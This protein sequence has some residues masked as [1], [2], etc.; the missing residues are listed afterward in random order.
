MPDVKNAREVPAVEPVWDQ[1]RA[2][3][4]ETTPSG[5]I[6]WLR[7]IA[8][9]DRR[10]YLA[11]VAISLATGIV[12]ALSAAQDAAWRGGAYDLRTPLLW[13]TSSV[14]MI[15]LLAPILF[16]AVWR[17]RRLSSWPLRIGLAVAAI[18]VFSTLHIAGM[19]GIRKL[20][21]LLARGSYDFHLSI[22]TLLYEFRK[23]LVTCALIGG[24]VWLIDNRS[25]AQQAQQKLASAA[26]PLAPPDTIWLRDGM[27]RIRIEPRDLLSVSSAGNY[28]EYSLANGSSHLI[29]GTL[30]AAETELARFK[31]ARVHRT[32]LVNLARVTGVELKPSGDFELSCDNGQMIQGSRRYRSAIAGFDRIQSAG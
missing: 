17:I 7:G 1:N 31:L 30:A 28:V 32:R 15:V 4:D 2:S 21:M 12:N 3:W 9:R 23:D 16:V 6:G 26:S 8:G 29:R 13:E 11:V 24:I 14:A 5:T 19:V 22:E 18:I 20:A 27:T 25:Q 10:L